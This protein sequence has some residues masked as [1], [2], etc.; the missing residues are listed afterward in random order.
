M[1]GHGSGESKSHSW[2]G[3]LPYD[4]C[5]SSAISTAKWREVRK[6]RLFNTFTD[7]DTAL[8]SAH[9]T[10]N[11]LYHDK[12]TMVRADPSASVEDFSVEISRYNGNTALLARRSDEALDMRVSVALIAPLLLDRGRGGTTT[13]PRASSVHGGVSRA[14]HCSR[15]CLPAMIPRQD[16]LPERLAR[17]PPTKANRVQSQA[18]SGMMLVQPGI[19][20]DGIVIHCIRR[21]DTVTTRLQPRVTALDSRRGPSRIPVCGN[22][23]VRCRWSADFLGDLPFPPILLSDAA[24][25]STRFTVIG[26][27]DFGAKDGDLSVRT[28]CH[29]ILTY[30]DDR[31]HVMETLSRNIT[32]PSI[33]TQCTKPLYSP[34]QHT[35]QTSLPSVKLSLPIDNRSTNHITYNPRK[36]LGLHWSG[37]KCDLAVLITENNRNSADVVESSF[38]GV[39]PRNR[40]PARHGQH[41]SWWSSVNSSS[42][43][44]NSVGGCRTRTSPGFAASSPPPAEMALRIPDTASSLALSRI[45]EVLLY[46]AV[47]PSGII[48]II[49]QLTPT[50]Y[51]SLATVVGISDGARLLCLWG[52]LKDGVSVNRP[53]TVDDLK[54]NIA[55]VCLDLFPRRPGPYLIWSLQLP[56][57]LVYGLEVGQWVAP[58]KLSVAERFERLLPARC[59]GPIRVR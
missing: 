17:S 51:A 23:T 26:S 18:G 7:A 37:E 28:Y 38:T 35:I 32:I 52:F 4:A 1:H 22:H 21:D 47:L 57:I 44:R 20:R 10:V 25:Y 55:H 48:I 49:I 40:S 3:K 58:L 33:I 46:W 19:R 42:A 27:Q 45:K 29:A 9:F 39:E 14:R 30:T 8:Q 12:R 43:G 36:H 54:A 31:P 56:D 16:T 34:D 2:M 50:L 13:F 24:T 11:S 53:R 41:I 5:V 6:E 15:T 59:S